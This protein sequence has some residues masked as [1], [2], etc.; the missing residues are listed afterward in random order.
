MHL[1]I[2]KMGIDHEKGTERKDA[3]QIGQGDPPLLDMGEVPHQRGKFTKA[4]LLRKFR[5][6]VDRKGK[7]RIEEV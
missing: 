6:R 2:V 4:D 5:M 1:S 3:I 7:R